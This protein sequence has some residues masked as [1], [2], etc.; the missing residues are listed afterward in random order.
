[1]KDFID[2]EV[3]RFSSYLDDEKQWCFGIQMNQEVTDCS[4]F[5]PLLCHTLNNLGDPFM[6]RGGHLHTFTY[7]RKLVYHMAELLHLEKESCWGY[8]TSGSSISNLQ[9]IYHAR[10]HSK[11]K[12]ILVT[13]EDAHNSITKAGLITNLDGVVH[14]RTE[15]YGG[16]CLKTF[17]E[18]V[19]KADKNTF[20][21]FVFCSGTVNKGAYDPLDKL[22]QLV[23]SNIGP[24]N[25]YIHLDA[26]LGG[27]ITPYI[28]DFPIPLDFR[29]PK[30][31]SIS[32]SFHKRLGMPF[33]GSIFLTR[34]QTKDRIKK[35]PII[36]HYDSP[37][38]TLAGS[39]NG[40][41]PFIAYC[42][43]KQLEEY[44]MKNRTKFVL[45]KA[46]WFN[47]QITGLGVE[48]IFNEFSPCVYF[49]L[50]SIDLAKKYHL[51]IYNTEKG[52][53]THIFTME[54]VT[55]RKMEMFLI[56]YKE[57]MVGQSVTI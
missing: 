6:G 55:K 51:P 30:V 16:L 31:D 57:V 46:K 41:G 22:T 49:H 27:L 48:T 3:N 43:L 11:G 36:E 25:Y 23:V 32:V 47:T 52:L 29:N 7:E 10:L 33:P 28:K 56:E 53:F 44:G 54:H 34:K 1:V 38:T 39:R 19:A 8:Y 20:Y 50:P 13:S 37:D 17:E 5:A 4:K 14:L 18:F 15:H 40:L 35:L 21:I 2:R 45:E 12:T 9:G 26:A 24:E 42:K